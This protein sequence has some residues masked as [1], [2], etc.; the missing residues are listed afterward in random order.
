MAI[1]RTL[2][3][4]VEL[5]EAFERCGRVTEWLLE[6][7]PAPLWDA[8]P[9]G[10]YGRTIRDIVAHMYS[11]R[12]TFAKMGG[13]RVDPPL[14]RA[15]FTPAQ[16]LRRVRTVNAAL[17]T[18]FADAI[19]QG[20][21]RVKGMPRRTVDMMLYLTQHDAHHRGQIMTIA[22]SAGHEFPPELITRMWGWRKG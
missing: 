9:P 19:A 4:D 17:T 5:L 11:L 16:M 2:E 20:R 12:R 15:A 22:K 14:G 18:L 10:N 21:T 13:G 1:R 6:E 3:L 7:I 8:P